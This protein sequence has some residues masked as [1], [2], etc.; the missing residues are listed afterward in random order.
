M[1]HKI[2]KKIARLNYYLKILDGLKVDCESRY[3]KDPI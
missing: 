3:I 2:E 1:L